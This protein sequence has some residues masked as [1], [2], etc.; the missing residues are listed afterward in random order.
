MEFPLYYNGSRTELYHE[1]T[2]LLFWLLSND[3][4]EG[5]AYTGNKTNN[6][7]NVRMGM[8]KIQKATNKL[9]I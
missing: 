2:E 8:G 3:F 4:H 9:I 5:V 6:K 1:S 7:G